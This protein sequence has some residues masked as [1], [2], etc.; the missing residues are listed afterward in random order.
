MRALAVK[1]ERE[2]S[3]KTKEE[4]DQFRE[5]E[6]KAKKIEILE[7]KRKL[8]VSAAPRRKRKLKLGTLLSSVT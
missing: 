1:K 7:S 3:L 8:L 5:R 4:W 6:M 2:K